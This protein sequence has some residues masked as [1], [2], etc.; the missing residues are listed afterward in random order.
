MSED[1][2]G[3]KLADKLRWWSDLLGFFGDLKF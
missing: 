1:L 3:G 2:G